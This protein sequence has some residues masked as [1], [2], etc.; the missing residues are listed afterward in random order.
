MKKINSLQLTSMIIMVIISA[1][2][3]KGFYTLVKSSGVD[4]WIGVI[5]SAVI[6]FSLMFLFLYIFNYEPDL[7]LPEKNKKLFGKTFGTII[8]YLIAIII[9]IT[10]VSLFY[11]LIGFISSQFLS[12]TPILFIGLMFVFVIIYINVKG[13]EVISR[14]SFILLII[15]LISFLIG[16]IGLLN[17]FEL[18]NIKPFLEFGIQ[19]P[20]KGSIYI[21][22]LNIMPT[23]LF[24]IVPK[25]TLV[26]NKKIN[27]YV[28]V[29]YI[30]SMILIFL[31]VI[32]IIGNLG[33]DLTKIYLYPEYIA[34]KRINIFNFLDR[35]ENIIVIQWIFCLI[36]NISLS[37]YFMTNTIKKN[38]NK[39]IVY[40]ITF[41]I[42]LAS[43]VVFKNTTLYNAY[44]YNIAIYF[45]YL[46]LFIIILISIKIK[47]DRMK[48]SKEN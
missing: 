3:G 9:F 11:D 14:T 33:I 17:N 5:I 27:A 35:I 34:L 12:E 6:G 4:A 16:G 29:G 48:K 47:I 38:N 7:P 36:I 39:L 43:N 28:T 1:T 41:L 42:L 2:F 24:L 21:L 13:I 19:P 25:N 20:I 37:V 22:M 18:S 40:I 44:V 46:L 45:K 31:T 23:I 32:L 8:N 10:S 15:S 26:D 30:I